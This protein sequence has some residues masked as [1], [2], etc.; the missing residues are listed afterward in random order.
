MPRNASPKATVCVKQALFS[1]EV[2]SASLSASRCGLLS[3]N[4]FFSVPFGKD[5]AVEALKDGELSADPAF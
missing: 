5:P 2:S 1:A 4:G 3:S